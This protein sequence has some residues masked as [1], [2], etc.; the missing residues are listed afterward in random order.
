M[1]CN[2]LH[3][4]PYTHEVSCR[5]LV[6]YL[7]Y[8]PEM[9]HHKK[10]TK[11]NNSYFRKSMV[12]IMVPGNSPYWYL[13]TLEIWCWNTVSYLRYSPLKLHHTKSTKSNNSFNWFLSMELLFIDINAPSLH[14]YQCT[15]SC[16]NLVL[17][18]R[19]IAL[20]TIPFR[21]QRAIT[22]VHGTSKQY[23]SCS[24]KTGHN[25]Y[26]LSVVPDKPVQSAQA[27]QWRHFPLL[28]HLSFKWSIF[29]A[30]I[31]FRRKM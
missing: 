31:L 15:L 12:T 9:L 6:V 8:S 23:E 10:T 27:N 5:N 7:R 2:A 29:L 30:N 20:K 11:G 28:W 19:Y 24:E 22:L 1:H 16:W 18:L 13:Y 21:K 3:C 17:Y 25:A 26:V 4:N 14:W